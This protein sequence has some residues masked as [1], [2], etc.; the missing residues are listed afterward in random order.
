MIVYIVSA[1]HPCRKIKE[2]DANVIHPGKFTW[3]EYRGRRHLLGA[4]AFYT[5][6]SAIRAKVGYLT[7]I[8][9]TPALSL[10]QPHLYQ[11]AKDLLR[12]GVSE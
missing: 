7:K 4:T 3:A 12:R 1:K 8:A 11:N 5:Q 6:A 9:K 10:I 2:I